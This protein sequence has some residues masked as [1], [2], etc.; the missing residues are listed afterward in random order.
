MFIVTALATL[1]T[2]TALATL[3]FAISAIGTA[4][5]HVTH[6]HRLRTCVA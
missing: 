6:G 3:T 4:F 5:G 1:A 2:F